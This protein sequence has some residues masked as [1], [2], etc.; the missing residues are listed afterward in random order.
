ME[1]L[2]IHSNAAHVAVADCIRR[3]VALGEFVPG[4]RVPTER[5]LAVRLAVGRQTIRQAL[6]LLALEGLVSTQRGRSGGTYV[7]DDHERP[8]GGVEVTEQLLD[9]VRENFDF[10]LGVEPLAARFAAERAHRRERWA[11]RGL[12][13]GEPDS[14]RSF[15][16]LDSRFHF[17]IAEASHNGLLLEAV[18]QS[19]TEFFR[20]ADAAWERLTW[21]DL[22]TAER[23]FAHGHRP[24][25]EAIEAGRADEAEELVAAHLTEGKAQYVTVVERAARPVQA[26]RARGAVAMRAS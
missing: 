10:R 17:A 7:L 18:A 2:Q 24:I 26:N 22:P 9:D 20:W 12:C 21:S 16:A 15:R 23:D 13:E 6:R 11:I 14:I 19:R 3:C 25:A 1:Q 5:D 4:D 8:R